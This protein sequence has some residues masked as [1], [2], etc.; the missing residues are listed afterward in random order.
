MNEGNSDAGGP[1]AGHNSGPDE[2][3]P[4]RGQRFTRPVRARPPA[5][6]PQG[7][8]GSLIAL[9]LAFS[10][11]LAL[12]FF[13][14]GSVWANFNQ[15]LPTFVMIGGILLLGDG[16]RQRIGTE[17]YCA[18]CGYQRTRGGQPA[19]DAARCP[20]CGHA[21]WG[22]QGT[23]IGQRTTSWPRVAAAALCGL[24]WL[25]LLLGQFNGLNT[26]RLFPTAGLIEAAAKHRGFD[27]Q[28]WDAISKRTL[29]PDQHRDLVDTLLARRKIRRLSPNAAKWI[30]GQIAAG[31]VPRDQ[32]QRY[33]AEMATPRLIL[34]HGAKP[35]VGERFDVHVIL[36]DDSNI[37]GAHQPFVYVRS[38]TASRD[39]A[40]LEL[41]SPT[42]LY[43]HQASEEFAEPPAARIAGPASTT[44][45]PTITIRPTA[46]GT[47]TIAAEVYIIIISPPGGASPTL[48]TDPS[49]QPIAPTGVPFF[50]RFDL[51]LDVTVPGPAQIP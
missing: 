30:E 1:P 24:I 15:T 31:A 33:F 49:G 32:L 51:K 35:T 9:F 3:S 16:F 38:I 39:A 41:P 23:V 34:A 37:F 40:V 18:K 10:V 6:I 5:R 43:P 8:R 50:Q 7:W 46:P 36:D 11:L 14:P 19:T 26:F 47:I 45:P 28:V 12:C 20:E 29:S 2:A 44:L 22:W 25:T 27:N 48:T 13:L 4:S 21:W 42:W 17:E